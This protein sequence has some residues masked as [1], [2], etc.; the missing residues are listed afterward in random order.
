[1][2]CPNHA[3]RLFVEGWSG[4]SLPTDV[5]LEQAVVAAM[6]ASADS[7]AMATGYLVAEDF[8]D[9]LAR[10]AFVSLSGAFTAAGGE[11]V[12]VAG[13]FGDRLHDVRRVHASRVCWRLGWDIAYH[14]HT[15]TPEGWCQYAA[16]KVAAMTKRIRDSGL[17]AAKAA[18]RGE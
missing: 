4:K 17:L 15:M 12:P 3:Q 9:E 13:A 1:M 6:H 14:A 16:E 7:L 10:A 8:T 11:V 18:E 5:A 2:P